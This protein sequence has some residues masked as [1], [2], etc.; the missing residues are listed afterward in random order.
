MDGNYCFC[1]I[2]NPFFY[3]FNIYKRCVFLNIHEYRYCTSTF[4]RLYCCDKCICW[5]NYL[6]PTSN[7]KCTQCY[8]YGIH[9][10]SATYCIFCFTVF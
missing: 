1:F 9:P 4:N 10:I 3:F 6:V 5:N 2:C 7:S 8:C